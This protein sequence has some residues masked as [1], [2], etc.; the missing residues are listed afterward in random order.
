MKLILETGYLPDAS[1]VVE[2][3]SNGKEAVERVEQSPPDLVL[4]DLTLE[5]E[6]GFD[7]FSRLRGVASCEQLPVIAVTAH[8]VSELHDKALR[9]GFAGYVTKPIDFET[10]LL[11]L[12]RSVLGKSHHAA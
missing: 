10:A 8:N 9:T 7:V 3:A 1:L 2:T 4:L 11:P 6:D 12:I 5:G